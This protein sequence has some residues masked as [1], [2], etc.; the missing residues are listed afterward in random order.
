MKR[1]TGAR[2]DGRTVALVL[3]LAACGGKETPVVVKDLVIR[4]AFAFEAKEGGTAAAY[5]VI[6]NGREAADVLD[7]VTSSAARFTSAHAQSES[8]GF[9]TMTPLER[10]T[11]ATG[12]SLLFQP[13]G[14][15]LMLE[16]VKRTLVAGDTLTITYWFM[17]AGPR[18][19]LTTVRAYGS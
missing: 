5:A 9:V 7:S 4:D 1:R 16:G 10:P 2:A 14:N 11:V 15:H 6:V 8:N 19:V 3:M 17:N 12:D 13:G 18:A